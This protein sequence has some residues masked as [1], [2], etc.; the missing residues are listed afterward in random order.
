MDN[1]C[2]DKAGELER[3]REQ[4]SKV[5][6]VVLVINAVM[7]LFEISAGILAGSVAL[8]ADSLDM[9]GDAIVYGF[10]LVALT[11]S[12]RWKASAAF[13]KG[14]I[15]AVFGLGVLAQTGYKLL[16]GGTPDAQLMST[17]G[18]VVLA[19]NATCLYML[20]RHRNDDLNMR[21]TWLCS[22]NDIIA[23]TGVILAAGSV[24]LT[25]SKWPDV[26]ISF[27]ITFVFLKSAWYVL[28][29]AVNELRTHQQA[30]QPIKRVPRSP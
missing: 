3:L 28:H 7:F 11:R 22:R 4:Q 14:M 30:I 9:L 17:T 26:I 10:S 24:Y 27:I 16:F 2:Q 5:L 15:M 20:T 13:L 6:W 19:A 12:P 8:L 1:C 29:A 21:S 25:T 18:F 23:N